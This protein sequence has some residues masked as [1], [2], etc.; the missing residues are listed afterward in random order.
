VVVPPAVVPVVAVT[1]P[2]GE[3]GGEAG[4][5]YQTER[6][7]QVSKRT[8][9]ALKFYVRLP[10]DDEPRV[11][12]FAAGETAYLAVHGGQITAA[13]AFIWAESETRQWTRNKEDSVA[14][15]PAPYQ[16][17]NIG[18]YRPSAARRWRRCGY[19][20][21]SKGRTGP[22][23]PPLASLPSRPG[24]GAPALRVRPGRARRALPFGSHLGHHPAGLLPRLAGP[25]SSP[26]D[27]VDLGGP[28]VDLAPVQVHQSKRLAPKTLHTLGGP[29]G[30]HPTGWHWPAELPRT[31]GSTSSRP[32]RK[33]GQ[34]LEVHQV[35]QGVLTPSRRRT[36][37]W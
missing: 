9:E 36:S 24:P 10:E 33:R 11:W 8:G 31:A 7:L 16:S 20:G 35:H 17:D 12:E 22:A 25:G 5:A 29:G 1:P 15:V 4:P 34:A 2:A 27:L 32:L 14:L 6:Y 3:E 28:L 23:Q 21:R 13:T 18:T 37:S 30:P 19:R 26:D